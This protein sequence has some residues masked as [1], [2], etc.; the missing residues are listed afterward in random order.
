MNLNTSEWKEFKVV[1]L[2][3]IC[4]G[5]YYSSDDYECGTTPYVSAAATNNGVGQMINLSPDFEGN[6]I[7]TGK[8]ECKAFYQG[9]PFCATSDANVYSPRF[10]MTLNVGLFLTSII[11]FNERGK[12]SYGR[13]CRV[14]DSKE[15]VIKLPIQYNSDGSP[16]LDNTYKYS[17]QGYVPDWQFME[18]YIKSLHYK[19][20]TTKRVNEKK[21]ELNVSQW[22]EFYVGD[23]FKIKYGINMELNACEECNMN[24]SESVAFVARTAENNGVSAYVKKEKD[25]VPQK[26]GTIT[27]AGGGSVL[28]TFVQF[29]DFYSGRDLYLLNEKEALSIKTKLFLTTIILKNQYK[30]SY[31]RQANKTLPSL[32]L[33]LPIQRNSD[34]SPVIDETKKYHSK[35]YIPD[36]QFMENYINSLP[37]SDRI[38]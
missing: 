29:H 28:S 23:V 24:D 18:D 21:I 33:K 4:A 32:V 14:G 2:F 27:C 37:Y 35:G 7:V 3:D 38:V 31:G 22:E 19:P 5:N 30:Y 10:D 12:W 36:W 1:K 9:K 11:T 6:K 25:K 15:I 34:G 16:L 13:Q 17:E 8:V 26:A 20:L